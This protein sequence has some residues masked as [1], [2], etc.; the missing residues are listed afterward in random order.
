MQVGGIYVDSSPA[1]VS[2]LRCNQYRI[3]P[4]FGEVS[5]ITYDL[6]R[7][8]KVSMAITDPTPII[9]PSIVSRILI[10]LLSITT[11]AVVTDNVNTAGHGE[12][13]AV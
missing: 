12:G 7:D 8:A 11:T 2:N 4:A 13:L 1:S 10:V 5:A 6:D 3:L 9:I